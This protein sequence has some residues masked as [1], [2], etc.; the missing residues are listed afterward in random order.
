[1]TREL[2]I[3]TIEALQKQ[4]E[5]D[6]NCATAFKVILPDT[7]VGLYDNHWLSNQIVKLLQVAMDD[8]NA[9]SWIEY[10]IYELEFGK[11]YKKGPVTNNGVNVD[12]SDAGKLFDFLNF[13]KSKK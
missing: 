12:I 6:K 9:Y 7:F 10:F 3:E 5:H 13:N 11:S 8:E 4:Y 1:M 2:F